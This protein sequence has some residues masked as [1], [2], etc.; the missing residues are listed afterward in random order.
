MK[1]SSVLW[2]IIALNNMIIP[3]PSFSTLCR[4]K[5]IVFLCL[6][7]FSFFLPSF[8]IFPFFLLFLFS[9]KPTLNKPKS[10]ELYTLMDSLY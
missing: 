5:F 2:S 8:F 3:N 9:N 1:N 6:C 7:L 10:H 4:N